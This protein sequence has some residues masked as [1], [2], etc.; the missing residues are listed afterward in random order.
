M[1][2]VSIIVPVYQN[3]ANIPV[4]YRA[5]KKELQEGRDAFDHEI[6]FVNDGSTDNSLDELKKVYSLDPQH[7]VIIDLL[8]NFG[9]VA[10]LMAGFSHST[11]D[12]VMAL[13]ADLQDPPEL[14]RQMVKEWKN[15]YA[16]VIGVRE[17]REESHIK[18]L[19]SKLFYS[20]MRRFAIPNMPVSGFDYFLISRSVLAT[21]LRTNERNIFLQGQ[22]LWPGYP[23]KILSYKRRRRE[24][25]RSQWRLSKKV[26]YFIDGFVGYSFFPIRLASG[27]GIVTFFAGLLVS[28][29]LILQRV[30]YGTLMPGWTSI[31]VVVFMLNG[32]Q[33]LTIGILGEYLWRAVE[34][35]RDRPLFI[36]KEVIGQ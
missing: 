3:E 18:R 16:V 24:L 21:V 12:C 7:V 15:G 36:I 17:S 23:S 33:M 25:G 4:T 19:G 30:L 32:L 31:M 11:G 34:Q 1:D 35:V 27:L 13:S 10:A 6:I 9:Q 28:I 26:K 29:V 14:I 5:I 22:I 2:K 20:L 8:R